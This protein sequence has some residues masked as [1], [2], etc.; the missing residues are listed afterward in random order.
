[1]RARPTRQWHRGRGVPPQNAVR[2][3]SGGGDDDE[4][5]CAAGRASIRSSVRPFPTT[6]THTERH[7]GGR[8]LITR[9]YHQG[10]DV[11]PSH[12]HTHPHTRTHAGAAPRTLL[13]YTLDKGRRCS[14]TIG[15]CWA[16]PTL[17]HVGLTVVSRAHRTG[18][19][20]D[21]H[22]VALPCARHPPPVRQGPTS[23]GQR[24][25]GRVARHPMCCD[26]ADGNSPGRCRSYSC[27]ASS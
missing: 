7:T 10:G 27:A 9:C 16:P 12:T 26:G 18:H 20:P 17:D 11:A 24:T 8:A 6:H 25:C 22:R 3:L 23:H 13:I 15:V 4:A 2:R 1:M 5:F 21:G 19:R 14:A